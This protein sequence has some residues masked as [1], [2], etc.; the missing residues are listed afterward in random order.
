MG[1]SLNEKK[2]WFSFVFSATK[3]SLR[4]LIINPPKKKK[5]SKPEILISKPTHNHKN[6]THNNPSQEN[7]PIATKEKLRRDRWGV[8]EERKKMKGRREI[9]AG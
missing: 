3:H 6:K 9:D 2:L 4:P 7:Q 8:E 5:K 1:L